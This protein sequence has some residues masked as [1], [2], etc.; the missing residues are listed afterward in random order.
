M[1]T[2]IGSAPSEIGFDAGGCLSDRIRPVMEVRRRRRRPEINIVPLIDVLIVLVFFFLMT[3]Q[4]RTMDRLDIDLPAAE[5]A[6]RGD[7]LERVVIAIDAEGQFFWVDGG[8]E[9]EPLTQEALKD[10]LRAASA[11]A[12]EA[13]YL[14]KADK[15]TPVKHLT[16]LLDTAKQLE[17][18]RLS[19]Q[20]APPGE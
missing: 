1:A 17:L 7:S 5:A 12:Q 3:M 14:V 19:L 6:G 16:W 2:G 4:F 9:P 18:P 10:R 13:T 11:S 8:A 20:T 15:E